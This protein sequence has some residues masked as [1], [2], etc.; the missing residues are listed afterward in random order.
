MSR[1]KDNPS[2]ESG[3]F[4]SSGAFHDEDRYS[5]SAKTN[6]FEMSRRAEA[7]GDHGKDKE[8]KEGSH[9]IGSQHERVQKRAEKDGKPGSVKEEH[10]EEPRSRPKPKNKSKSHSPTL[11]PQSE[12]ST[13]PKDNQR[14]PRAGSEVS[15]QESK[16][17]PSQKPVNEEHYRR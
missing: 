1:A 16:S 11:E 5:L 2:D 6:A 9:S 10:E 13:P 7:G 12:E 8:V 4:D 3:T 14:S 17:K 15:T